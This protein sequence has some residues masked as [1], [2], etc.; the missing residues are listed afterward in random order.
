MEDYI[1]AHKFSN[2]N[3]AQ[4]KRDRVCGCFYCCKVF[5]PAEIVDWLVADNDCDR[6]GTAQCPYCGID[7]IIA[8]SSGF[9]VTKEFLNE[10]NRY[11]FDRRTE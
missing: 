6:E 1:G 3:M 4:L 11:W 9:P 7:S 5:D 10:M 8:E 2:N